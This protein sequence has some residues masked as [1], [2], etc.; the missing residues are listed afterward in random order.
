MTYCIVYWYC[1]NY[2][3]NE[4]VMKL[5]LHW[6]LQDEEYES[7]VEVNCLGK[8]ADEIHCMWQSHNNIV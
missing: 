1:A 3:L 8:G 7:S 5:T 6:Q 2:F 4:A